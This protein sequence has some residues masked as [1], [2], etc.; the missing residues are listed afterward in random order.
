MSFAD[1]FGGFCPNE[2]RR[3]KMQIRP[4]TADR[5]NKEAA[6]LLRKKSI[7]NSF[8]PPSRCSYFGR[9]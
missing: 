6:E 4:E 2:P 1:G 7:Y 3:I 8:F 5:D 9:R